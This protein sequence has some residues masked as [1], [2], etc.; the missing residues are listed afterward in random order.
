MNSADFEKLAGQLAEIATSAD[1][2]KTAAGGVSDFLRSDAGRYLIGGLGGAG[3]GAILGAAQ[4]DKEKRKRNMLYYGTLGGLGGL[5]V[6]HLTNSLAAPQTSPG[7]APGSAAAAKQQKA[8]S[9]AAATDAF[10]THLSDKGP[11]VLAQQGAGMAGGYVG[12]RIGAPIADATAA[13]ATK[14]TQALTSAQALAARKM[15]AGNQTAR[16]NVTELFGKKMTGIEQRQARALADAAAKARAAQALTGVP[17][18]LTIDKLKAQQAAE[19]ALKTKNYRS[20]LDRLRSGQ[21]AAEA[22]NAANFTR[23]MK[24]RGRGLGALG[25][26]LRYGPLAAGYAGGTQ[27]PAALSPTAPDTSK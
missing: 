16:E 10:T 13:S 9:D 14:H 6:A 22:A 8:V 21:S 4:P 12:G 11:G 26:L 25:L 15:Q 3:A 24:N 2:E 1:F 5:G 7:P 27:L 18:H 17:A 20:G 23:Q 19:I